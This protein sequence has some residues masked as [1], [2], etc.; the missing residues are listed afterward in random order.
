M[1]AKETKL[2]T[3][4]QIEGA[5]SPH[6]KQLEH[7]MHGRIVAFEYSTDPIGRAAYIGG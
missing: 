4:Q 1:S 2:I 6:T 3:L 5:I 7:A